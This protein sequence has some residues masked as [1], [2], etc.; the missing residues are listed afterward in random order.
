MT[1]L[2]LLLGAVV[3]VSGGLALVLL[4]PV[5]GWAAW[6]KAR[7][8]ER[9]TAVWCSWWDSEWRGSYDRALDCGCVD[10]SVVVGCMVCSRTSCPTLQVHDHDP[11]PPEAAEAP[12]PVDAVQDEYQRGSWFVDGGH[13]RDCTEK[14][15]IDIRVLEFD[16]HAREYEI[17]SSR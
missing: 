4:Q 7:W 15:C 16:W 5:D 9:V 2:L 1:A 6:L 8:H 11:Y 13:P 10:D 17:G 12:D 14:C 3:L